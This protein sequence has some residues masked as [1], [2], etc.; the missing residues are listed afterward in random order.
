MI[1]LPDVTKPEV[2]LR[3]RILVIYG[4]KGET[5]RTVN[6]L[7]EQNNVKNWYDFDHAQNG[8]GD[9]VVPVD[10]AVL[11]GV[12]S[13]EV[14]KGD[15]SVFDLKSHVLSLHALL[16]SLDEVSSVTSRFFSGVTGPAL[17]PKG[18]DPSRFHP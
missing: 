9:E 11:A 12:P 1:N 10:S 18:T 13:F 8:D 16:P 7:D 14:Q 2:G 6:V 15:V 4:S 5:L 17:V 3:D